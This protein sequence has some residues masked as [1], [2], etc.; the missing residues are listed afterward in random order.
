[1]GIVKIVRGKK[2]VNSFY[3][4]SNY[5]LLLFDTGAA[6]SQ[7][8]RSDL[9]KALP[10]LPSEEAHGALGSKKVDVAVVK[11]LRA[12]E[13][14]AKDLKVTL[15]DSVGIL[16]CDVLRHYVYALDTQ[17][18]EI[19]LI[20]PFSGGIPCRIGERG[21]LYV[22]IVI[23]GTACAAL[24]DTGASCSILDETFRRKVFGDKAADRT[25]TGEDWTGAAFE[26]PILGVDSLSIGGVPF[27]KHEF[28]VLDFQRLFPFMEYPIAAI[29]GA[30][31]LSCKRFSINHIDGFLSVS[32]D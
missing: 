3:V 15:D 16:G 32:D 24:I 25:E 5:G 12:G 21:H 18:D 14:T 22:D 26:T 10:R 20:P 6:T 23:G 31:T 29:I 28:A 2:D 8:K 19:A 11:E 1:M 27:P 13:I 9:T 4:S 30:S 17:R 7:M